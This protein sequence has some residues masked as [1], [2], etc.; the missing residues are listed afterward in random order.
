MWTERY[1][2]VQK[3]LPPHPE[4]LG[5]LRGLEALTER[6]ERLEADLGFADPE[7]FR[8]GYDVGYSEAM[9]DVSL[10]VEQGTLVIPEPPDEYLFTYDGWDRRGEVVGL[11]R[12][13]NGFTNVLILEAWNARDGRHEEPKLKAFD[14]TRLYHAEKV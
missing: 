11:S 14:P 9:T 10:V 3:H 2:H 12:S 4:T 7:T 13:A 1:P 6:V 5:L 8:E